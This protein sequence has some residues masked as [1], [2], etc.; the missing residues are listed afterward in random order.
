MKKCW[1]FVQILVIAS[2]FLI[3]TL[4]SLQGAQAQGPID[5]TKTLNKADNV[6]RVGELLSFTISL[7]NNS[8]FS[9]TNATLLDNYDQ[10]TLAFARA[11]P[12]PS[13]H[14]SSAGIITWTNVATPPILPGQGIRV[15]VFFTAEHPRSAVVNY[16]RAEDIIDSRGSITQ[17]AET[18]RTQEA[19]GG[20]A[21]VL[22]YS[23]PPGSMPMAGLPVTFTHLI[24]NDGA[25]VMTR[26]PLTDTYE[27]AFL[28]F[29][30]A[31]PTPT[32]TTTPGLLVWDD[33][34][35]YFGD[36]DPFETIVVTT[37]F[38]ATTKVVSTTNRAST[39][40]AI[41]VYSNDLT[42]GEAEAPIT[43][44]DSPSTATPT[45]IPTATPTPVPTLTP[46]PT[47]TPEKESPEQPTFTPIPATETPMP[48]ATVQATPTVVLLPESGRSRSLLNGGLF[49]A[50]LVFGIGVVILT[51][52]RY[53]REHEQPTV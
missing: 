4:S 42:A 37:V 6:V 45:P 30:F 9:L 15:T 20:S 23:S 14:D 53:R 48:T 33:L 12:P 22:K 2:G 31:I 41:D 50:L 21:P 34:T 32:I 52:A 40:G 19:I 7:T 11:V 5:M 47:S 46:A 25:A 8:A 36:L 51:F 27:P 18:S 43:I 44:I 39:E 28:A 1:S 3:L 35:D 13:T 16:A 24:T 26:L 38:T 49:L 29:H 10:T 17:T